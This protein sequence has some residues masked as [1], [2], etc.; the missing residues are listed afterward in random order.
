[1]Y[2]WWSLCTGLVFTRMS[3]ESYR[4]RL[5]SLLL[6]LCYVFQTLN[7]LTPLCVDSA[8]VLWASF[9]FRF[10]FPFNLEQ[11]KTIHYTLLAH[12]HRQKFFRLSIVFR[13]MVQQVQLHFLTVGL[14]NQTE[15]WKGCVS[16]SLKAAQ[17]LNCWF[18]EL[19]VIYRLG[20]YAM[21]WVS[22]RPNLRAGRGL[23]SMSGRVSQ[24]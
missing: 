3:D 6:Y 21:A 19:T 20:P 16:L 4:R 23:R 5:R 11:V 15:N 18:D 17:T 14:F 24:V 7:N 2:L 22:D 12:R 9:C 13:Y 8:R 10:L 1:M